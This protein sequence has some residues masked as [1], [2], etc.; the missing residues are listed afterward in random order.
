MTR[1]GIKLTDQNILIG[2]PDGNAIER[3]WYHD[4]PIPLICNVYDNEYNQTTMRYDREITVRDAPGISSYREFYGASDDNIAH[5]YREILMDTQPWGGNV[6]DRLGIIQ[7]FSDEISIAGLNLDTDSSSIDYYLYTQ[8]STG[9]FGLDIMSWQQLGTSPQFS[10]TLDPA[11]GVIFLLATDSYN[12]TTSIVES[13]GIVSTEITGG[14]GSF[15]SLNAVNIWLDGSYMPP[16]FWGVLAAAPASDMIAGDMY[17]DSVTS[18][19]CF[20]TGSAWVDLN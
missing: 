19:A 12:V 6:G 10:L 20:Y 11:S 16:R 9:Q 14:P 2:G 3:T 17:Y 4:H 15:I 1:A 7:D 8:G 18:K 13:T 5:V